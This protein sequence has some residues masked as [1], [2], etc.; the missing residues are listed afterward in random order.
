MIGSGKRMHQVATRVDGDTLDE[1]D[2]H[3]REREAAERRP[4]SRSLVILDLLV[5]FAAKRRE[6]AQ[7]RSRTRVDQ[8]RE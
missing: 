3:M 1:I 7:A 4:L 5:S 2:R 8:D 6:E